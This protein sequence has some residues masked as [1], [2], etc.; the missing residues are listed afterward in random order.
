MGRVAATPAQIEDVLRREPSLF[1]ELKRWLAQEATARGQ[2]VEET[3]LTEQAILSRVYDDTEFRAVATRMLQKYGFLLPRLNPD[4]EMAR[5]QELVRQERAKLIAKSELE[6]LE[7]TR[8]ERIDRAKARPEEEQ[9][10]STRTGKGGRAMKAETPAQRDVEPDT[11][12][13]RST[14]ASEE[15]DRPALRGNV[16][17]DARDRAAELLNTNAG[18]GTLLA[19]SRS[20]GGDG[21]GNRAAELARAADFEAGAAWKQMDDVALGS[22][23][24]GR[25]GGVLRAQ[26]GHTATADGMADSSELH[27]RPNPYADIPSLYDLYQ[28][29]APRP[30]QLERFGADVFRDL[31]RFADLVPA[32]LPVGPDYVVGP[33]DGLTIDVWGGVAQRITRAVDRE[34]RI[35]LPEVGPVLVSGRTLGEVQRSVQ[36]L[37][38]TQ[39][40][41]VSA[42]VSLARLRTI[43]VYV[44]GDVQR[45]GPYEISSLSTPLNALFTAAGPTDRGS[46]R[47]LKH[48]R[49]KT[50]VQEVDVYD[51]LLRGV[52]GDVK[53]LENGDTVLVPPLGAQVKVEGMVRRPA[54]Y[55]MRGEK[56]L[57]EVLEL[58]GGILPTATLRNIQVQRLQTNEKRTMLSVSIAPGMGRDEAEKQLRAFAMQDNDEVRIFPIAQHNAEAVYLEGHVLRPGRY[59]YR[60]GMKV[61]DLFAA[62]ADLLPEPATKYA[63]IVHLNAP[64]YRPSVESFNLAAALASPA[65]APVLQPL[66]TV[67]VFSRY[68]FEEPPVVWVGGEVFRPGS[69]RTSGQIHLRDAV[70]LAGGLTPEASTTNAQ[71]FRYLPDGKLK[72]FSVSLVAALESNADDN[73]LLHSRDRVVVHRN[74]AQIDPASV[75]VKGEVAKPGRYPLTTNM[76]IADL[77]GLAGG[78]K[79]SAYVDTADLTRFM[80]EGNKAPSGSQMEISLGAAL[81]RDEKFDLLLRDGDTL[82]VRRIPGWNDVGASVILS[83]EVQHPGTYGITPGEKLSSLLRRAGAFL[84]TAFPQGAQLSR[85]EVRTFQ[86]KS[87]QDLIARIEREAANVRVSV[88]TSAQEQAALQQAALLQQQRVLEGL[89]AA[90]VSGRL[91]I[92]LHQQLDEFAKS[93]DDIELR[94]G[95]RIHIPKRPNFVLVTGQV[96][97]SNAITFVPN[98]S[99]E[100]YLQ[101]AGGATKLADKKH[102]FIV[103]ASGEVVSGESGWWGGNALAQRVQPG[104]TIVVP[105]RPLADSTGLRNTLAIAQVV[106]SVALS[107]ALIMR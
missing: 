64:D 38:Q 58:A 47:L 88:S 37:L 12:D 100:W 95:D 93:P 79:R 9:E 52:R 74:P 26:N 73:V 96:Y 70:H 98:K 42:D 86:E 46:F 30:V 69:Y 41:D 67:R 68:D 102:I 71:I 15:L 11:R 97:N 56:S 57:A 84:P 87:K 3:D 27:A 50:L 51:L 13:R 78:L 40:R 62:Y 5:E 43:R 21:L 25:T 29:A 91:V 28:Q 33:G 54:I 63:E 48:Y 23:R 60:A 31:D 104:D 7:P 75:Y 82:T 101:R 36:Q 85:L 89:R 14:A 92:R 99:G 66:D 55:E 103:R 1:L 4:S 81:A 61:T 16:P 77:I 49:G 39:F 72:I 45:P 32:D 10:E 76:H 94:A 106:S 90:P 24:R 22:S 44:V 2:I 20:A 80:V 18:V 34:G 17:Q 6:D 35:S 83:G 53:R 19:V 65:T 8:R 59:S 105:E 107:S